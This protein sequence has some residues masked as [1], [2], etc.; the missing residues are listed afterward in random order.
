MH[1][2]VILSNSY[3]ETQNCTLPPKLQS[4]EQDTGRDDARPEPREY[5]Q[6]HR[7]LQTSITLAQWPFACALTSAAPSHWS[8]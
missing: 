8:R 1:V 2:S 4:G 5:G 6:R 7:G 3:T